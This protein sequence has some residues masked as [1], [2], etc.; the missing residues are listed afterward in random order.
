MRYNIST[1]IV[2]IGP[3]RIR[4][5]RVTQREEGGGGEG[6]GQRGEHESLLRSFSRNRA[7]L[8][9]QRDLIMARETNLL[10]SYGLEG[11]L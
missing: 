7:L 5:G 11:T 1:N 6:G 2:S 4:L 3:M 10:V 9:I 8:V